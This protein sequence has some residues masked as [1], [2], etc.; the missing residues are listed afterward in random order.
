MTEDEARRLSAL[1]RDVSAMKVEQADMRRSIEDN[2]AVTNAVKADTAEIV[3]LMKGA[4]VLGRM[5]AWIA[6]LIGGYLAGK[7]LKWW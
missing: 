5:A 7:G 4:G 1:E 2:T 6:A 3:A